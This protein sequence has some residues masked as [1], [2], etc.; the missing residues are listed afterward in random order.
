[1]A[2]NLVYLGRGVFTVPEAAALAGIDSRSIIR[3]L[4]GYDYV[5]HG[6]R[7][8]QEPV[9]QRD[10]PARNG[11]ELLSFLDLVEL[12][13]VQ[14]FRSHGVG[15]KSIRTAAV[16]AAEI[17]GSGHPFASMKVYSDTRDILALIADAV[18]DSSLVNLVRDQYEMESVVMPALRKALDFEN[19]LAV[20]WWPLGRG[21]PVVLDPHRNFGRPTVAHSGVPT[22]ILAEAAKAGQSVEAISDWYEV[23]SG[24]VRAAVRFEDSLAA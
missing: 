21:L 9:F 18:G 17:L 4:R 23:T 10:Y 11:K 5:Y 3:W 6:S 12:R 8:R 20:R 7:R 19:D 15:W 16:R 1:M 22:R 2:A 13:F 24:E 14:A